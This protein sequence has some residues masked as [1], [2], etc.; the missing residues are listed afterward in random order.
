MHLSPASASGCVPTIYRSIWTLVGP[1]R[2]EG[3][4]EDVAGI[5][6]WEYADYDLLDG[7]AQPNHTWLAGSSL[8]IQTLTFR[9]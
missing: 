3:V 7:D 8:S 9:K 6:N 2:V 5:L 4:G 1:H